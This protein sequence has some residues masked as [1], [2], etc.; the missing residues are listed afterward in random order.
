[1]VLEK[2]QQARL[3][4]RLM[5]ERRRL[6]RSLEV[7]RSWG[8]TDAETGGIGELSLY[9]QHPADLGSELAA[10]QADLGLL[11]HTRE[12]LAQVERALER[13]EAG[14]YGLCERCGRPIPPERLRAVPAATRCAPCQAAAEEGEA[15]AGLGPEGIP[16]AG[17]GPGGRPDRRPAE[18]EALSP[19]FGR[20]FATGTGWD[21]G[22]AWRELARFGTSNSPQDTPGEEDPDVDPMTPRQGSPQTEP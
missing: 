3:R 5:T 1:M 21:G 7:L 14:R 19:P 13:L 11:Q 16:G 10:R 18:E 20:S 8:W 15:G 12:R 9:D 17:R 2:D 22:D 6:Q 4:A